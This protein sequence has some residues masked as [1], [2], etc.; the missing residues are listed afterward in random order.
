MS[1]RRQEEVR[2]PLPAG[3]ALHV[4]VSY[5]DP[6]LDWAVVYVHGF[7]STRGG[8]KATAL[9]AACTRRGWTFAAFDFRG[10]G[11]STGTLRELRGSG[12]LDDLEQVRDYLVGRGV[13]RLCLVGSS[14]GGWVAAWFALRHPQSVAGTAL[15]APALDFVRS[16]WAVLTPDERR[17]WKET[18]RLRINNQWVDAELGYG[19]VE[20]IDLFPL[21][22][23]AAGLARPMLILHG[24]QD[25][26]VP[27]RQS[28]E[29]L[30]RAACPHMELRLYKDGDHRLL[31]YRDEMAD[32]ACAF[33]ARVMATSSV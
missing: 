19:L 23:L 3:G 2:L 27:Y 7:A 28:I 14:M 24:L 6:A 33:F 26:T 18:G 31:A 13:G 5:R 20:E 10:H 29:F 4:Y 1:E 17:R 9:E 25:D 22:Q 21:D 30:E 32:T 11:Q 12:L 15:I 16:R 8:D